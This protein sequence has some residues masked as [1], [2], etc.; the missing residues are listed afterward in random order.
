M[1]V[2]QVMNIGLLQDAQLTGH[3]SAPGPVG[4]LE[5]VRFPPVVLPGFGIHDY[6]V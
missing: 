2:L 6:L 3:P 4:D 5:W 1:P